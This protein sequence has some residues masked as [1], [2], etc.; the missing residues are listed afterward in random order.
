MFDFTL[1]LLDYS[2]VR[3]QNMIQFNDDNA[4][5]GRADV[6]VLAVDKRNEVRAD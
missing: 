5:L 1:K 3:N 4:K 2:H 6:T